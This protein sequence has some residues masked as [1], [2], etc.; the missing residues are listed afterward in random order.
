MPIV[1]GPHGAMLFYVCFSARYTIYSTHHLL[2]LHYLRTIYSQVVAAALRVQVF[3]LG[4]VAVARKQPL[5]PVPG[6]LT[7]LQIVDIIDMDIYV[8]I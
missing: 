6:L 2:Y 4:E 8:D 3:P 7:H 1:H 5:A